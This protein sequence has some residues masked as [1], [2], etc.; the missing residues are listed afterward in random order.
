[1]RRERGM[2]QVW[3]RGG[4]GRGGRAKEG[5]RGHDARTA[6]GHPWAWEAGDRGVGAEKGLGDSHYVVIEE[7]EL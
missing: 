7:I 3:G 1:M 6:D 2:W 5:F 4:E